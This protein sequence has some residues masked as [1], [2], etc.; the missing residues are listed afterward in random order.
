MPLSLSAAQA[1][2][3]GAREQHAWLGE[4]RPPGTVVTFPF[5]PPSL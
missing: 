3:S 4:T 2:L 5:K 1:A